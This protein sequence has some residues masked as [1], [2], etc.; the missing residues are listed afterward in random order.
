MSASRL[1]I[2]D[3]H[4][5]LAAAASG[6]LTRLQTLAKARAALAGG[7][8]H[9]S[10]IW[11]AATELGWTGLALPEDV[12]GSGFGL[13]ELAVV[14]ECLGSQLAPGPFLSSAAAAVVVDR[15]APDSVR[16]ELLPALAGGE[17]VAAL[18]VSGSVVVGAD[19]IVTGE[20]PVV[21]AAPD[22]SLLVLTADEDVVI[23][24]A[25]AGGVT[26]T[27]LECLDPTRS[28]G[29]V[30][31]R[32]VPV[33]ADRVLRGAARNARTV[34]RI[35]AAAEGVGV[36][37]AALDMAVGYAKVREQFG[38]TI[39]TFQAV[40]H[41]AANML[42]AAEVATAAT[43]DAA[44]ADDLDG[45]WFAGAVAAGL[46]VRAQ[47]LNTQHNIQ[48]HGGI[49]YTWEHDSHLYLRRA[50]T[51]AAL[52]ADGVDPLLD[53]VDGQRNG[54]AHGASFT[55]PPESEEYRSQAREAAAK[56]RSLPADQQRDFLVES[57][58]LVPHWPQ[59]WGRAATVL[60]Q[61]VIEEEFAGVDR[62]DMGITGWV[63]L[64]IAQAG[65]DDQRERW[66]EPVLRG[67]VMWCQLFSEPGAGSDAAA[68]R[69]A[70]KKVDGGW[71]VTGQ[72]VWTSLAHLCQWGL[73]TVRTDPDAP[74]HA[75]VTMMAIDMNAEGVT[76]NPLRGITGDSHFNEVFFDDVFVPDAD[77]VGDVNKGW[78][79]ARATLGNERISIGGGSGGPVG[80]TPDH[81]IKLLDSS[82]ATSAMYVRQAGEV[83]AELH[84]LRLLNLRRA[85]R[86][87]AGAEPGPEG[88]VTK[89][90]VAESGQRL[91]EL[92]F[93]LAGTAAVVG[94]TPQL[95]RSYLGN[96]AMTIAGGTSEITRN[97]IAER[98]LGL[99]RDPLLR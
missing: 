79:V 87:I 60:E 29:S 93:E 98:I 18:G 46:A 84:S 72:K 86:A 31:L 65:T 82:P 7:S 78:L 70:A 58:Y 26:V 1:A 40:K 91:T 54:R 39:G 20:S 50:R 75:G 52:M 68:V 27:P 59:P 69:T 92:A 57:G 3:D 67:Q 17:T 9:P 15:S 62:P 89:L 21:L 28:I 19:L 99:P 64:T 4:Q 74:K 81:L 37:W 44:R 2:T 63:A 47:V 23:V 34:F 73:A 76:V 77:V 32:D 14:I 95:T 66:V 45:A 25:A 51:L 43:W 24:D 96:R 49:G 53:I 33:A 36:G 42:V 5:N 48:L 11:S 16:G 12:G 88:N 22:A 55:L 90:L 80:T 8:T 61:L 10:D 85:T 94:Q 30:T 35:L 41:H 83:I 71:R 6:Q 38:R 97:T 13:E 56:V